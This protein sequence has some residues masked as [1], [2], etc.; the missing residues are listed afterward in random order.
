MVRVKIC[1]ITREADLMAAAINGADA[2]GLVVGFPRSPR[3]LTIERAKTLR[4][5]APPF[6]DVVLVVDGGDRDMLTRAIREIRPDAVQ[7][8]GDIDPDQLRELGAK[9]IIKPIQ[10]NI[11]AAPD[12]DGFDAILLDSS[13]GRG[14]KPDWNICRR[15]REMSRLPVILAGGLSPSNIRDAI[16]IVR[17]YGVDVSSGV[18]SSPGIKDAHMIKEFVRRVREVELNEI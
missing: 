1:G 4:M 12:C 8:Y 14:L 3:N 7:A 5:M 17:P 9:W 2:V 16:R 15:I 6:L 18:E 11:D 13:M 10:A